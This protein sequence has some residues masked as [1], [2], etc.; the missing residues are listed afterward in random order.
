MRAA[1]AGA[2]PA[3]RLAD[4][5]ITGRGVDVSSA[6]VV[7]NERSPTAVVARV[8]TARS[9]EEE[10]SSAYDHPSDYEPWSV[11][12][13]GLHFPPD[14]GG[15]RVV[16]GGTEATEGGS[17]SCSGLADTIEVI[18][19]LSKPFGHLPTVGDKLP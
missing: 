12:C 2:K 19:A 9:P 10:V 16:Q 15:E 5:T 6:I 17:C 18:R 8:C 11:H 13:K 14:A 7:G 1:R 4:D 3:I